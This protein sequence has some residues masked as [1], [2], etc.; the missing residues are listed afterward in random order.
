MVYGVNPDGTQ[1][2]LGYVSQNIVDERGC[3]ISGLKCLKLWPVSGKVEKN[4]K[5]DKGSKDD[6]LA[7]LPQTPVWDNV[8]SDTEG[9][10]IAVQFDE[11]ELPVVA[12]LIPPVIQI[13]EMQVGGKIAAN[14]I[15]KPTMQRLD[16]VAK[17]DP[18]KELSDEDKSLMWTHRHLFIQMPAVLPKFLQCVDWS[19]RQ[20][21]AEAHRLLSL[22]APLNPYEALEV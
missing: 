22:W 11:F 2:L 3:L 9:S 7:Y 13:N 18:L 16:A 1:V 5:F 19:D 12:P 6:I 17:S 21:Q 15:A 20:R 8:A 14:L 4:G 10:G